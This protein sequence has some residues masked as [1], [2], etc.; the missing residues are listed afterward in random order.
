MTTQV[1]EGKLYFSDGSVGLFNGTDGDG[2][3][4]T[5]GT[6]AEI[7]S[8]VDFYVVASSAGSQFPGKTVIA[9]NV[10][11]A[12]FCSYAYILDRAGNIGATLTPSSR[13]CGNPHAVEPLPKHY[14]LQPGDTIQ[15]LTAA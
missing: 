12:T 14:V 7:K 9:S 11:A 6:K 4:N 10:Q 5:D 15:V 3:A 13:A 1:V 2:G 8:D